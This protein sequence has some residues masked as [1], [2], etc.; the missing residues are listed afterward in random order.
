M[1]QKEF[2]TENAKDRLFA[3]LLNDD[4]PIIRAV[5]AQIMAF[6]AKG[7]SNQIFKED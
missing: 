7:K 5:T 3:D 4:D 2:E 6:D 1:N